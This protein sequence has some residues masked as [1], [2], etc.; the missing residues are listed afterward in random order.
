M[1]H[2]YQDDEHRTYAANDLDHAK[3]LWKS[4]TG[5]DPDDGIRW[6]E[7]PDDKSITVK[8]EDGGEETKTAREWADLAFEAGYLFGGPQ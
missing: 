3:A 2:L 5:Q 6:T 8:D 1:L 7:I 4:D